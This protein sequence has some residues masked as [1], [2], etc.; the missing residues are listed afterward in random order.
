MFKIVPLVIE[1]DD[2]DEETS[3]VADDATNTGWRPTLAILQNGNPVV[4]YGQR[5]DSSSFK[6]KLLT[7]FNPACTV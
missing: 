6:L 4:V 5:I 1:D 7:C 2:D 3:G